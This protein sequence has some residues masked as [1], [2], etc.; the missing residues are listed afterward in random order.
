MRL[1]SEAHP[2]AGQRWLSLGA[3]RNS[4]CPAPFTCPSD[5]VEG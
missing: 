2:L 5:P 4:A 3:L 1:E